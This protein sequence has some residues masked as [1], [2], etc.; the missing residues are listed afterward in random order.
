MFAVHRLPGEDAP[1]RP[2]APAQHGDPMLAHATNA[3]KQGLMLF[4]AIGTVLTANGAA[5]R[6][7]ERRGEVE[8]APLGDAIGDAIDGA[9]R[10]RLKRPTL[11]QRFERAVRSC[12]SSPARLAA[13]SARGAAERRAQALILTFENGQPGLILH[14]SPLAGPEDPPGTEPGLPAVLGVLI[15]RAIEPRIEPT[16]LR[17]LFGLTEAETRVAEAYLTLDTVKDVARLIGI[18]TNTVKKHLSA[19]YHKTGCTRQAQLVRLLMALS[20]LQDDHPPPVERDASDGFA[21]RRLG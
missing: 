15:D 2:L 17:E 8:L 20:E 4:D 11:H 13:P 14:L 12:A 5:R 18:S 9:M 6:A 1:A 21:R 16:V 10:L 7:L 19:V 3:L